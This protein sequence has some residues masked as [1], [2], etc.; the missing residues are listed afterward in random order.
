MKYKLLKKREQAK[1]EREQIM[2]RKQARK[3]FKKPKI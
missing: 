2:E 1:L 3:T